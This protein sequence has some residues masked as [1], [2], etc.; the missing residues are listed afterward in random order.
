MTRFLPSVS[1]SLLTAVVSAQGLLFAPSQP[2]ETLSQSGN[3]VLKD[4]RPNEVAHVEFAPCPVI[5]AEKWGPRTCYHAMAGDEDGDGM[6]YEPSLFG[7]IDALVHMYMPGQVPMPRNVYWSPTAAMGNAISG[8]VV[9]RPGDTGRIAIGGQVLHF[10]SADQVQ[11]ALGMPASP[12]VVDVDAI[13]AD[14]GVGI[15]FSLDQS[16]VVNTNCGTTFVQDGDVLLIPPTAITWTPDLRVQSLVPGCAVVVWTEAQMDAFVLNA[17]VTDRFGACV[18]VVQDLE[19]LD[20]DF[21]GRQLPFTFC[22]GTYWIPALRFSGELMTGASVLTTDNGGQI[23]A[24]G[25]GQLGRACG[26]GPTLGDQL[27]LRPPN[28]ALGVPSFVNALD[29]VWFTNRFVIEPQQHVITAPGAV[30]LD[31]HTPLGFTVLAVD[32]AP[33]TVAPSAPL[34]PFIIFPDLFILGTP[35]WTTW[36]LTPGFTTIT[37]PV[38]PVPCKLVWQAGGIVGSS[39][40]VS[41]PAMLDVL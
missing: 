23:C 30:Q 21:L 15:F 16:H 2:E 18:T 26:N 41:A 37:T 10:L 40:A 12:I 27:G 22:S 13:A 11:Q 32:I 9:L 31:I 25:C 24:M 28:A 4:L 38:I 19:S 14:G 8:P 3:T 36:W 39:I 35:P 5:S 17:Q 1:A 6:F 7:S 29:S 20:I 33:P 34:P